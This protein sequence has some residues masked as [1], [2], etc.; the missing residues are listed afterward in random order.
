MLVKTWESDMV[1]ILLAGWLG[2]T[3]LETRHATVAGAG[4]E[5][6]VDLLE[7][8]AGVVVYAT[9]D[10]GTCYVSTLM[11]WGLSGLTSCPEL[12]VCNLSL[13]I[14][15]TE[16]ETSQ[17]PEILTL[18]GPSEPKIFNL[19]ELE[20]LKTKTELVEFKGSLNRDIL[21][22]GPL[23]I[24]TSRNETKDNSTVVASVESAVFTGNGCNGRE[25]RVTQW[26]A[27]IVTIMDRAIQD[28]DTVLLLKRNLAVLRMKFDA[29]SIVGHLNE[30]KLLRLLDFMRSSEVHKTLVIPSG[31]NDRSLGWSLGGVHR[32]VEVE[33][34]YRL[35]L[36]VVLLHVV[37]DRNEIELSG[38]AEV[39]A[40]C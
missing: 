15:E 38:A 37:A 17:V 33:G 10:V 2:L 8:I 13:I 23:A 34:C 16:V 12:H 24:L 6:Y 27:S 11:L 22:L 36:F 4:G 19:L 20:S 21:S 9:V 5:T 39:T 1:E 28:L 14:R 40:H 18:E 7:D 26:L 30:G 25:A 3:V 31:R 29:D 32:F 35:G